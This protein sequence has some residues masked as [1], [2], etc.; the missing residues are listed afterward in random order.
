MVHSE[1]SVWLKSTSEDVPHDSE[2]RMNIKQVDHLSDEVVAAFTK[3][4]PQLSSTKPPTRTELA[5]IVDSK[6]IILLI[7]RND[8]GK[9]IGTLTLVLFRIPTGLR[10]RIEDVIVDSDARRQGIALALSEKA[11]ELARARGALTIDLTSDPKRI[12]AN[13]LYLKLGCEKRNTNVYRYNLS[14]V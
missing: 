8:E 7:A 13:Q 2:A 10:A 3:L 1:N 11:I 6:N 4:I 5:E 12:A 14:V 9:I